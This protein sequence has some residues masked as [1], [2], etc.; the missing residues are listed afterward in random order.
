MEAERPM[1]LD[2]LLAEIAPA[3]G[4]PAAHLLSV[5]RHEA[6]HALLGHRLGLTVEHVTLKGGATHAGMT[7]LRLPDPTPDRDAL[8]RRV[9]AVL[10]GRAADIVLGAGPTAGAS[11]D[12]REATRLLAAVHG[13]LGLGATLRAV[14]DQEHA[15][16]LL[17]EDPGLARLV[18]TDLRRLQGIAETMVRADRAG[19]A[20][21]AS[22]LLSDR[23]VSGAQVAAIAAS[24]IPRY[25]VPA[26]RRA[27]EIRSDPNP[28]T[29][30]ARR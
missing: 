13:S 12:L 24:H 11:A 22:L 5:S 25:R 27:R 7:L 4:R 15:D 29:P 16:L 14:I 17:R 26:G 20:A 19:I 2:D 18:E 30:P 9:V 28:G 1:R 21:L 23:V 10:G 6:G 3:D 8:E